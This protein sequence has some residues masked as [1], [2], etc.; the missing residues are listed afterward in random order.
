MLPCAIQTSMGRDA[1]VI[2]IPMMDS[3]EA[4]HSTESFRLCTT[5]LESLEYGQSYRRGQLATISALLKGTS[6]LGSQIVARLVG[7]DMN[8]IDR[9]EH[10]FHRQKDIALSDVWECFLA[11]SIPTR[12]PFQKD[13]SYGRARGNTSGYQSN[14]KRNRKRLDEFFYTGSMEVTALDDIH[15]V[16]GNLGRLGID[17][18]TDVEVWEYDTGLCSVVRGRLVDK[19]QKEYYSE[20]TMLRLLENIQF[21]GGTECGGL[22]EGHGHENLR[23]GKYCTRN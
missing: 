16:T 17:F 7:G 11:P 5:H 13:L 9:P 22:G 2:D 18:K 14:D 1:L 12:K 15:D 4:K 19:T 23:P 3:E 20:R 10:E 6:V 8:A 21:S